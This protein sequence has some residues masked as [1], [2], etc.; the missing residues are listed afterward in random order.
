MQFSIV[1][2][3]PALVTGHYNLMWPPSRIQNPSGVPGA[4]ASIFPTLLDS[5]GGCPNFGCLWLNQGCQPGCTA[6]TDKVGAGGMPVSPAKAAPDACSETG[7]TMEPTISDPSLRT[8][9]D[10]LQEGDWTKNNPWRAPGFAPVFSPCGLAGGGSTPGDWMSESLQE[11]IRAG[12][13]TPPFI[14]RGYDSRDVPEGPKMRWASGSVQEVAWS[15][16]LNHG[17]G[18]SYRLCPKSSKLTEECFQ[19]NHLQFASNASWIQYGNRK[20]NRTAIPA[21]RVSEG[22]FPK[23]STWTKNPIPPC[24]ASDWGPVQKAQ[25]NCSQPMFEPPL[26]GLFGDGPGACVNW[27]VHGPVEGY[28]IFYDT[29]GNPVYSAPCTK[30][31]ALQVAKQFQFNVFD[32]VVVPKDLPTGEY[33]LSFR[34]DAEQ[35][36]QIWAQCADITITEPELHL[37]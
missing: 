15:M 35:T 3:L 17:G 21:T 5:A 32:E 8:Y 33:V 11:H 19:K 23:G 26:P 31:Q 14:R 28:H 2:I 24:M 7:G 36:P 25:Y 16:F 4:S 27:A 13:V 18:Y 20:A 29:F 10:S 12:A 37:V 1:A 34:L 22:T 30:G 9:R 6:C